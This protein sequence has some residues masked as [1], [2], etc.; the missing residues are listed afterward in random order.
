MHINFYSYS[1]LRNL[2]VVLLVMFGVLIWG[3]ST[4]PKK[5][6]QLAV[7][8]I[9][10]E[11]G[12][13]QICNHYRLDCQWDAISET[14]AVRSGD[15]T[16]KLLIGS[17]VVIAGNEKIN[18][19]APVGMIRSE[20]IVP[21][22][23]KSKIIDRWIS[24]KEEK[25]QAVRSIPGRPLTV[26]VDAGHGGKDPGAISPG[27]IQEKTIVLDIARR[28]SSEL[29][30]HGIRVIMIRDRDEFISLE[31]RT[32]MVS[33]T[34][35]D[36]FVSIHANAHPSRTISGV[37]V[38]ALRDL[39]PMEKNEPQ[40]IENEKLFI[41]SRNIDRSSSTVG[42]IVIDMLA[43]RKR[44]TSERLAKSVAEHTSR[45]TKAKNLGVKKSRFFV[46]R[47]TLIPSVL[48]EVGFLTHPKEEKLL[49]DAFYRQ[50]IAEGIV[51]GILAYAKG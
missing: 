7:M 2:F 3:C 47:H 30:R 39:D 48:V 17:A 35:A 21:P 31:K 38:Y 46:L 16:A 44:P 33:R 22:D 40:H 49:Q 24:P 5:D 12:L 20:I 6:G 29:K 10:T 23:F 26:V 19:S 42:T 9:G 8:P 45:S 1:A 28:V 37:E 14:V 11:T 15:R 43:A 51:K 41:R 27:G 25:R 36:F 34:S 4:T 50:K 32:E 18:L 13:K